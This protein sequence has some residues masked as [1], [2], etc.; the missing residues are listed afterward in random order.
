MLQK[1]F[2]VPV[3][4]AGV[5]A[6][7]VGYYIIKRWLSSYSFQIDLNPLYFILIIIVTMVIA[8]MILAYHTLKA[9]SLNPAITLKNE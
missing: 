6:L 8:A 4:M 1:E 5:I 2:A 9:A 3:L 7:P